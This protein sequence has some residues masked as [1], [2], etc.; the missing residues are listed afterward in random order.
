MSD[1]QKEPDMVT[2]QEPPTEPPVV[3][4]RD[5]EDRST[6]RLLVGLLILLGIVA[7][8]LLALLLWLLRPDSSGPGAESG[9]YPIEVVTTIYG[10]GELANEQLR[11]PLGVTMD[12]DGNVWLSNSGRSRVEVYTSGGEFIRQIGEEKGAGKL[13][14]PYGLA[15]DAEVGRVYVADY[16]ARW[17]QVFTTEGE[18]VGHFPNDEQDLDVFGPDG[19]SPY[20]VE[21][22]QGRVAV[23]SNDGIYFF[24]GDGMVVARWGGLDRKG[25]PIRGAEWGRFNFPDALSVDDQTGRLYVTDSLNRRVV[26]LEPDGSWAWAS[27]SPDEDGQ[28]TGFW[29]LP[30]GIEVGPDGNVYVIDTFRS[31]VEGMGTGSFVVLSPDGDLL[32]EFGRMGSDDGSFSFPEHLTAGPD[33]LW[34]I[35][36]RENNRVVVFRLITPYPEVDDILAE[37]YP[38]GFQTPG[39]EPTPSAEPIA[40]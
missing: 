3:D 24:D 18:Y 15:V 1:E 33:G 20:D 39:P 34:A 27:G 38:D 35:A 26:A 2:T 32:S 13:S 40:E 30:R 29:Q 37:R 17:V 11:T 12:P 16:A 10:Y 31:D 25:N 5:D 28:I 9:G 19:F 14:T 8:A 21:L 36:D 23:S 6:R 7:V 4:E 22:V